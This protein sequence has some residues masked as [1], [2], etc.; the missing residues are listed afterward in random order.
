VFGYLNH[1]AN[2][3]SIETTKEDINIT[4]SNIDAQQ[5]HSLNSAKD[6][7]IKAGVVS[8]DVAGCVGNILGIDV[9]I[10]AL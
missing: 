7:N 5:Q 4:G 1:S 10:T 2:N 9:D 6:I 3:L 8:S